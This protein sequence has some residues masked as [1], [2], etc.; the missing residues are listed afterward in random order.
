[1]QT[2]PQLQVLPV[3]NDNTTFY[4]DMQPNYGGKKNYF[5]ASPNV[6]FSP[7]TNT[8][9]L[10]SNLNVTGNTNLASNLNVTGNTIISSNLNV[11]GNITGTLTGV[12]TTAQGGTGSTNSWQLVP[13]YPL[14]GKTY[15]WNFTTW[16]WVE[17][18][19]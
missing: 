1:M 11:T 12:L 18:I 19:I 9:N 8:L 2:L 17:T 14:D 7:I 15:T 6:T 5:Y 13:V 3:V 10:A 16:S 4:L